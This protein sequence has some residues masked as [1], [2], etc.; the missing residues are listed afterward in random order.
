MTWKKIRIKCDGFS[1]K[2]RMESNIQKKL[3]KGKGIVRI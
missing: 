1:S 3:S 2:E